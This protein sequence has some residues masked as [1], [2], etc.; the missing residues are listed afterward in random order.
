[1]EV[2]SGIE[3]PEYEDWCGVC[4]GQ[5]KMKEDG[6]FGNHTR[7]LCVNLSRDLVRLNA[8]RDE[9][10]IQEPNSSRDHLDHQLQAAQ[11][12]Y[13]LTALVLVLSES[14]PDE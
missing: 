12:E 3:E 2:T 8:L 7:L 11:L 1:M 9:H 13:S 4:D 5:Y 6:M 10:S 14:R